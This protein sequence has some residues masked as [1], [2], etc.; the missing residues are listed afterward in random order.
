[1]VSLRKWKLDDAKQLCRIINDKRITDNLRSLPN[2]YTEKDATDYISFCLNSD[3]NLN[4]CYAILLD[5]VVVGS[6]GAFRQ[7][8]IHFRTAEIGYYVGV[9]YW[10]KGVATSAVKQL[11]EIIFNETDIVRLF[12]EPFA[13]NIASC[14]ILEKNGFVCDGTLRK[15]A[16]KNGSFM[17]MKMYSLIK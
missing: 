16:Y 6:I 15:N 14:R 2:P 4:F 9:E 13:Q 8:D 10:G 17:D 5:D 11:C 3:E 1:M 12:A 7:R